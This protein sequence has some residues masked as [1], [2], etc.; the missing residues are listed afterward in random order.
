MGHEG[1][2]GCFYPIAGH[3]KTWKWASSA[4]VTTARSQDNEKEGGMETYTVLGELSQAEQRKKLV[5]LVRENGVEDGDI[6]AGLGE[7]NMR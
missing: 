2:R 3:L 6:G 4:K 1:D 7:V 5:V